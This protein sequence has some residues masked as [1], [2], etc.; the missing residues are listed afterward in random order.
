MKCAIA[1][2]CTFSIFLN[3][4]IKVEDKEISA[5]NS[6]IA[7]NQL[8]SNLPNVIFILG[9]HNPIPPN[10]RTTDEKKIA[11]QLKTVLNTMHL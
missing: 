5:L 4:C 6:H 3:A 10:Q 11:N 2:L 7:S 1:F 8:T 9:E